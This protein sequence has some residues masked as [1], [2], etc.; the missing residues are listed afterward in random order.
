MSND[1]WFER[2]L[3]HLFVKLLL[4]SLLQPGCFALLDSG[5]PLVEG[6]LPCG[7]PLPRLTLRLLARLLG[8]DPGVDTVEDEVLVALD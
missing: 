2:A 8:A 1:L 4:G 7:R 3:I 6:D 5:H